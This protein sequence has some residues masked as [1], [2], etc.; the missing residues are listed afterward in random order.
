[1]QDVEDACQP[2]GALE[3]GRLVVFL[4]CVVGVLYL[5]VS[6]SK[7]CLGKDLRHF[8]R[9]SFQPLRILISYGQVVGQ[10]GSVL[11][12]RF[13]GWFGKL[14]DVLRPLMEPVSIMHPFLVHLVKSV[15]VV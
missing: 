4:C 9:C 1:M 15:R 14:V 10:L 6:F 3:F 2:C 5:C 11:D 12:F 7:F 13:P 8:V